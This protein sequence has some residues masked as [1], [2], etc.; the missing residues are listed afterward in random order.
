VE[1]VGVRVKGSAVPAVRA[2]EA[3]LDDSGFVD[4][5]VAGTEV[6][7]EFRCADCGYGAVVQNML[8]QCPMCGGTIWESLGPLAPRL[9]D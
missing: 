2:G 1:Q 3:P 7:G 6:S 4:F 8:P 9:L 5:A